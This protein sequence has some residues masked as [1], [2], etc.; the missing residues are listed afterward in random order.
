[1]PDAAL[2][3]GNSPVPMVSIITPTYN[4]PDL[5][6]EAIGSVL[7][8]S[9]DDWEMLI[10]D[11]GSEP[12]ARS[13]V[14]GFAD[15]RLRY[16]RL[17]HVGRSAAR[18]C[19][20]ELARG[21]YIGFLDDDD[22]YHPD[23]LAREISFLC[24]HPGVDIVGSGY[25][26]VGKMDEVLRTY[27]NWTV[28]P[29]INR[30]NCLFG[31]PL[32]TCSVLIARKAIQSMDR[33]FDPALD[34]WEDSD[35]FRRLFL[36]GIRFAWL[37]EVLSDYRLIH[38]RSWSV[39]L[40]VQRTGRRALGKLF[41]TEDLPPELAGQRQDALVK[42]DLDYAWMAYLYGA[43]NLGQRSMLQAL[44][45]EPRLADQRADVVLGELATYSQR[46]EDP[47]SYID[48]V[49]SHLPSPLCHLADRGEEVKALV[50]SRAGLA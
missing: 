3:A 22:L 39:I 27:E 29:E 4:R 33:W 28:K 21:M 36:T 43:E 31:V 13:V 7:N 24:A 20:L 19:G 44:V 1:M 46:I 47:D 18:N 2:L 6:R 35:F 10:V 37:R 49:L 9:F 17:D 42:F 12:G 16:V 45:R 32:A 11:D 30:E 5:L 8:Q 40:D 50:V 34:L 23:K 14:D 26:A 15:P 48:Y 38:D 25:R 41:E